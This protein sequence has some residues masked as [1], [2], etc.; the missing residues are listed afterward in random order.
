MPLVSLVNALSLY[1]VLECDTLG[2]KEDYLPKIVTQELKQIK[3]DSQETKI[4]EQTPII[5][6]DSVDQMREVAKVAPPEFQSAVFLCVSDYE[7][8]STCYIAKSQAV[9]ANLG[10]GVTFVVCVAE[11]LIPFAGQ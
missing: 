4:K 1:Q 5:T 7:R 2:Y 8:C 3:E 10:C 9:D 6:H 11:R